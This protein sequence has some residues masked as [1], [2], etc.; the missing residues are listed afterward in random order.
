MLKIIDQPDRKDWKQIFKRPSVDIQQLEK[1]VSIVF[2]EVKASGDRAVKKNTRQFDGVDLMD[3]EV[4]EAEFAEADKLISRNLRNAI[5]IA[6]NNI[7]KFHASQRSE[8]KMV[9]T[10][11]GVTCWSENKPIESVGLYIPGRTA[12]LFSTALMLGIPARLAGC[13]EIILCTPPGSDGKIH[14]TILHSAKLAGVTRVFKIGGIQA[15]AA[16]TYGTE[17]VPRVYKIFGPGNPY[18]TAAKR[19]AQQKGIAIDLPTG[20]SELMVLADDTAEADFIAADLLSRAEQATESQVI[21]LTFS[22]A[23]A[24]KILNALKDQLKN[25]PR[26]AIATASL[27]NSKIILVKDKRTAMEMVNYYAPEHLVV[28]VE[29]EGEYLD[30]IVNAGSVF[31]GHYTPESAGRYA[32]GTNHLLPAH[33]SA[34]AYSGISLESFVKKITFQRVSPKGLQSLGPSIEIMAEAEGLRGN[35]NAVSVRLKKLYKED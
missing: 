33:G 6:C 13:K 8:V 17:T 1:T 5:D 24:Q 35:K 18:V 11:P 9:D 22:E 26:A 10:V 31:L 25:L 12:P 14:S 29:D 15:I 32:A 21:L 4:S 30:E 2:D 19:Y 16:M 23:L 27:Q 34:R 20:P 7:E 3:L 28:C